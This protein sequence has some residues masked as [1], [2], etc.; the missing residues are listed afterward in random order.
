MRRP[1]K[2]GK[3]QLDTSSLSREQI[4]AIEELL[5]SSSPVYTRPSR[6]I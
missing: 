2:D 3:L 6:A 4:A 5:A 1:G